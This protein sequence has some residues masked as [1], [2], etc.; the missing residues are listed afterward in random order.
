MLSPAFIGVPERPMILYSV[1]NKMHVKFKTTDLQIDAEGQDRSRAWGH[2]LKTKTEKG[3]HK[4]YKDI[5][6]SVA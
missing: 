6:S 4:A 5:N 2:C 3:G 1:H